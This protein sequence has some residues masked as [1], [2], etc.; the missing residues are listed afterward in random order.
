MPGGGDEAVKTVKSSSEPPDR[1]GSRVA[2]GGEETTTRPVG[3][4][5]LD[6][7]RVMRDAVELVDRRRSGIHTCSDMCTV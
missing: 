2:S 7:L 1:T 4:V 5:T 6:R 3:Y